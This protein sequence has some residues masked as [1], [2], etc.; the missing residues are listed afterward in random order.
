MRVSVAPGLLFAIL[1]AT[2]PAA[3][4][5]T[6]PADVVYRNGRIYTANATNTICQ[7]VAIHK[8]RII[9]IGDNAGVAR[10]VVKST[11][12][13]DLH[14]RAAMPG[15]IDAHMHSFSAGITLIKCNL[16]YDALTV[17]EFQARIQRCL[18]TTK[19]QEPDAWLEVLGW[20]QQT[21]KPAGVAT[22]R[23]TLDVLSALSDSPCAASK[24]NRL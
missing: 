3:S 13:I 19:A 4:D 5:A 20:N 17:P 18:D 7:A 11:K 8:G 21:M 14:G 23:S 10:F 2:L 9:Y 16:N 24:R 22:S 6:R 1:A 15:I 12:S